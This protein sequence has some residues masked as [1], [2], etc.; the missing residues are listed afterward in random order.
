MIC[1]KNKAMKTKTD[2]TWEVIDR[3]NKIWFLW[4]PVSYCNLL[5]SE[6]GIPYFSEMATSPK[7]RFW[8]IWETKQDL[9][10]WKKKLWKEKQNTLNKVWKKMCTLLCKNLVLK[11]G[12]H[13]YLWITIQNLA[14]PSSPWGRKESDTTERLHFHFSL[15]C[16]GEGNGNSLQCSCLENPRD[17]GAWWA[18]V[19]GV[20]QSWTR[21]KWLGSSSSSSAGK[22]NWPSHLLLVRSLIGT[23]F[24]KKIWQ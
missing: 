1:F 21:L 16:I 23:N 15:S 14:I 17:G 3:R 7:N 13:F 9:L 20:A 19:Y 6:K 12:C 8:V 10:L 11:L 22:E 24:Q 4:F 18:T 2:A 5:I